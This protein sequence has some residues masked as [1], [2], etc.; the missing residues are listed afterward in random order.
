[1]NTDIQTIINSFP[2][3]FRQSQIR[4]MLGAQTQDRH[5]IRRQLNKLKKDGKL[6]FTKGKWLPVEKPTA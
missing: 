6:T 1:M 5:K 4:E 3:G 2:Q